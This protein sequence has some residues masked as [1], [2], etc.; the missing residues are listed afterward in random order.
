[1]VLGRRAYER[2]RRSV[3]GA[4]AEYESLPVATLHLTSGPVPVRLASIRRL[5][6]VGD[7]PGDTARSPC[8]ELRTS[9]ITSNGG[10]GDDIIDCPCSDR[11]FC[12]AA[13]NATIESPLVIAVIADEHPLLQALREE[14]RPELADVDG[15]IGTAA[16]RAMRVDLDY[17]NDR[18]LLDCVDHDRCTITPAL[19][20]PSRIAG[21][22][23]CA[24]RAAE[25]T[26]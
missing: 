6:I 19:G 7:T 17:P 2:Y 13:A 8:A 5:A 9:R 25:Q 22:S 21:A 15:L 16:L 26:E 20:S 3:I 18:V 14:L 23:A 12:A 11:R 4:F 1:M 10:C 24:S